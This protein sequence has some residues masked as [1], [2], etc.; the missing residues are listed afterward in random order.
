MADFKVQRGQATI[1]SSGTSVTITAGT[2][3]TAPAAL[4]AAFIR[5]TNTHQVGNVATATYHGDLTDYSA[6]VSNPGNLLTS[7]AFQRTGSPAEA[8][9]VDWEIVEYTGAA[10]GGNEFKV[11]A[12]GEQVITA[13]ADTTQSS[14]AAS[15]V[16]D[17]QVVPFLTGFRCASTAVAN[18]VTTTTAW[19]NSPTSTV[20]FA[21]SRNTASLAMN[22]S[23]AVV[24][25]TGANWASVQRVA[26]TFVAAN[27]V[28]TQSITA[29]G[30]MAKV[31]LHV[32]SLGGA[33][34]K[35]WTVGHQAYLSSTTQVSFFTAAAAGITGKVTVA[36]V[37][38]NTQSGGTPA[39][40]TR[41][42]GTTSTSGATS[43]TVTAVAAL[44][45]ASV[46]GSVST[47]DDCGMSGLVSSFRFTTTTNVELYSQTQFTRTLTYRLEA[48][49]WPS[50]A[51]VSLTD[52]DAGW[53]PKAW[54]PDTTVSVW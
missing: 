31:F 46:F 33:D 13:N 36:W 21:R 45:Q 42:T 18:D 51:T 5:I 54:Q 29:V 25:F 11:R 37:V 40:S 20:T 14:A 1:A 17:A 10:G 44:A 39:V 27:A 6:S 9:L 16:T 22:A 43:I 35:S 52:D 53:L 32:Q 3:Y 38:E 34:S 49:E 8:L 47:P 48:F 28:E 15:V 23:Y 19:N 26:H 7:I 12:Q 24:E 50:A 41:Y 30:S 4:T 2:D